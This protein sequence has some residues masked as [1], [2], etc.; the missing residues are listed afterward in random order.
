MYE[1][2]NSPTCLIFTLETSFLLTSR[3]LGKLED[4][5]EGDIAL[6]HFCDRFQLKSFQPKPVTFFKLEPWSKWVFVV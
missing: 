6:E 3:N 1:L 2:S 5:V 4:F